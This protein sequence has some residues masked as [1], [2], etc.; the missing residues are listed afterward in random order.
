VSGAVGASIV[1]FA[2][3]NKQTLIATP[4]EK[5]AGTR[6]LLPIADG[7]RESIGL[8]GVGRR[9]AGVDALVQIGERGPRGGEFIEA[10]ASDTE[11]SPSRP[12]KCVSRNSRPDAA[13]NLLLVRLLIGSSP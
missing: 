9:R 10:S 7:L 5:G 4:S 8:N 12:A 2:P 1:Y 13:R 3:A 11:Y 6:R